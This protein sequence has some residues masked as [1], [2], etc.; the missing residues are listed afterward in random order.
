MICPDCGGKLIIRKDDN[1]KTVRERLDVYGKQTYPLIEYYDKQGK[2]LTVNGD[3]DITE[4]FDQIVKVL[5]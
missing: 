4:V 3:Q 1:V 5:G 2:L